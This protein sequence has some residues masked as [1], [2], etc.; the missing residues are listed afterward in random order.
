[1]TGAIFTSVHG[2]AALPRT[3]LDLIARAGACAGAGARVEVQ[4]MCFAFTDRSIAAALVDL[5][6]AHPGLTLRILADWSQ[7]ARGGASVLEAMAAEGLRNLFI[8]FKLDIPYQADPEGRL[9]YSYAASLGM[10]HHK[11]L[12]VVV[13]GQAEVMSLGSYNWTMRGRQAYENTL[14][15]DDPA[16]LGPFAAE[17]AALWSDHRLSGTT[18]RTRAIMA[19][20]REDAA[21]GHDLRDP[22]R[23]AD[24]LGI[25]DA[26]PPGP[27]GRRRTADGPVMVAF[28]GRCPARLAA[29][30]G[31]APEND[32]RSLDLLRPSGKR[33]PAPLTLNTL[34][35]EAIRSV[36]EGAQLK[37][38][39]YALSTRVPEF[40]ALLEAARRGVRVQILL[41]GTIG[42]RMARG[43]AALCAREGLTIDIATTR[44]RMHQKYLCCPE[45]GL[46]LSG[47]ANMTED[48]TTR[49]SDHRILWRDAPDLA[50]AFA[51]DFDVIR[52]R[53][54]HQPRTAESAQAA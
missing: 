43:L 2:G 45:T 23:L 14:L 5:C 22:L 4:V 48:A 50:R 9:R 49:H 41:D 15:L 46:V 24:V 47:T 38:A 40:A 53:L 33:R 12:L 30:A 16:V 44:R 42:A 27:P 17:F 11:T 26:P 1:M 19:R 37:L 20:L 36:P 52:A 54:V 21:Q 32:R 34:A 51:E 29:L 6:R 25:A 31:H 35:L 39:I 10:L 28:S 3:V 7:S 18:E 13:D 8:K